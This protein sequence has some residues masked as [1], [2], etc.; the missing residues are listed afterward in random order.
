MQAIESMIQFTIN[1]E[2]FYEAHILCINNH[3]TYTDTDT[4][5]D[6]ETDSEFYK[7]SYYFNKYNLMYLTKL[8][9]T[10]YK[11]KGYSHINKNVNVFIK[12]L[13][14]SVIRADDDTILED[15]NFVKDITER[16]NESI[17]KTDY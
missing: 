13:S 4:N 11:P 6:D 12:I 1:N 16:V 15:I 2:T 9:S 14:S 5:I 7:N 10:G 17:L 3:I 8:Y